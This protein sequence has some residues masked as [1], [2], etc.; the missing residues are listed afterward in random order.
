M[1]CSHGD[2]AWQDGAN[3]CNTSCRRNIEE[4]E[5]KEINS[6]STLKVCG[7]EKNVYDTSPS[8]LLLQLLT[9]LGVILRGPLLS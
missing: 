7:G 8:I 5:I 3:G 1:R 6:G 2:A 4:R 9:S